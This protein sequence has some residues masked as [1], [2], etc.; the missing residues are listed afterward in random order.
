M[1]QKLKVTIMKNLRI[2][3]ND[4]VYFHLY[5]YRDSNA[6][7]YNMFTQGFIVRKGERMYL[8]DLGV[9]GWKPRES[10]YGYDDEYSIVK[11]WL[12]KHSNLN[13]T[14]MS[15][16]PNIIVSSEWVKAK[17]FNRMEM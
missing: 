14:Y 16:Y 6:N 10:F 3:K 9:N 12:N 15:E 4:V 1:N 17:D 13:I 11:E 2:N 8:T 7:T 5:R